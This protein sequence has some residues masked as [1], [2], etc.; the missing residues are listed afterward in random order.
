[1]NP[2]DSEILSALRECRNDAYKS[3]FE[4]S[5]L[6]RKIKDVSKLLSYSVKQKLHGN[7]EGLIE[8]LFLKTNMDWIVW[9]LEEYR[10]NRSVA[11]LELVKTWIPCSALMT[12]ISVLDQ[13][14]MGS[15]QELCLICIEEFFKSGLFTT[16]LINESLI[17]DSD[18]YNKKVITENLLT[19]LNSLPNKVANSTLGKFS[20]IFH[21]ELFFQMLSINTCEAIQRLVERIRNNQGVSCK[22]LSQM[23]GSFSSGGKRDAFLGILFPFMIAKSYSDYIWRRLLKI[24]FT[25]IHERQLESVVVQFAKTAPWF[26]CMKW[27]LEDALMTN[28]K[29]KFL[30]THKLLFVRCFSDVNILKNL[31]GY[32]AKNFENIFIEVLQKLFSV[33]SDASSIKHTS[34]EQHKY[35]TQAILICLSQLEETQLDKHRFDLTAWL[36]PGMGHHLNST[37]TKIRKLG[38]IVGEC[39]SS[40]AAVTDN[41]LVFEYEKNDETDGLLRLQEVD[42]PPM[43]DHYTQLLSYHHRIEQDIKLKLTHHSIEKSGTFERLTTSKSTFLKVISKA[44][45]VSKP[46]ET[47]DKDDESKDAENYELDSDDDEDLVPYDMS[48]YSVHKNVKAPLYIRDCMEGLLDQEDRD[49]VEASIYAVTDLIKRNPIAAKEASSY[50]FC[51]MTCE[52]CLSTSAGLSEQRFKQN[53]SGSRPI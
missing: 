39:V 45:S 48:H 36:A 16:L 49:K 47:N 50:L 40:K 34:Y 18:T 46:H 21:H 30:L 52:Y 19:T 22:F 28:R 23:I 4:I 25:T 20:E 11:I 43:E 26:G 15:R 44:K 27:M 32:I 51:H 35:I 8:F 38:M 41:R 37:N 33:W 5:A 3:N 7:I 53:F 31:I 13:L 10:I 17:L 29:L 1:M 14:T 2:S 9:N 42:Q 24:I 12:L 6:N